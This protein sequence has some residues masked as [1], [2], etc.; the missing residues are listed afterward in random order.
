MRRH[1]LLRRQAACPGTTRGHPASF[2]TNARAAGAVHR[3]SRDYIRDMQRSDS[4]E[5]RLAA[6]L[7]SSWGTNCPKIITSA[8]SPTLWS[9][10]TPFTGCSILTRTHVTYS[11]Y[12]KRKYPILSCLINVLSAVLMAWLQLPC[13]FLTNGL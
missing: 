1:G 7:S 9:W 12:H 3:E 5:S 8:K 11:G 6:R 10:P 2:T 4:L 13:P